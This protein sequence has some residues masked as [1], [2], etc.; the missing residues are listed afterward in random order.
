MS[1][2]DEV[3]G[4]PGTPAEAEAGD[5]AEPHPKGTLL[6]GVVFLLVLSGAWLL[7]YFTLIERS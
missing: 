1:A 6:L 3:E 7:M 5:E 2:A 4:A